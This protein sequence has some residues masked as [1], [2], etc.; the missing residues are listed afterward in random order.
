MS[1]D[2]NIATSEKMGNAV[3]TGHLEELRHFHPEK[4]ASSW[5]QSIV[6]QHRSVALI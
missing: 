4:R 3:N 6:R 1:K 2:A 5:I